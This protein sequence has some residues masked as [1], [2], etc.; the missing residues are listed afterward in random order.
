MDASQVTGST[1]SYARKYA[2]NGLFCIDDVK[3]AD[4]QDNTDK[5]SVG[6]QKQNPKSGKKQTV[7]P[8]APS[9][10]DSDGEKTA[11]EKIDQAKLEVIRKEL[12]RTGLEDKVVLSLFKVR[13]LEEITNGQFITVMKKF[14]ATPS[15]EA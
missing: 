10:L 4:N 13:G 9:G 3:D 15:K 14:K 12:E 11:A 1:S 8:S 2:L 6:G 7:S 5:K